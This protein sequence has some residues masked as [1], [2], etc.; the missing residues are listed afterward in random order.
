[1]NDFD[2]LLAILSELRAIRV[3][4]LAMSTETEVVSLSERYVV[5]Q[6]QAAKEKA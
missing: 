6:T 1:M 3:I 5:E 2:P 4:L